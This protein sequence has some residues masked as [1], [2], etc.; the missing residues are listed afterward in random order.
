[1]KDEGRLF[2]LKQHPYIVKGFRPCLCVGECSRIRTTFEHVAPQRHMILQ[3][4]RCDDY[5]LSEAGN[6]SSHPPGT[7]NQF[8]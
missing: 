6:I 5:L 1:M 4:Y 3:K 7:S 8:S 2:K